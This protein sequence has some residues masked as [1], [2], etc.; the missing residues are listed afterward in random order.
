MAR[1]GL[2]TGGAETQDDNDQDEASAERN[3]FVNQY[4]IGQQF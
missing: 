2:P 4:I 1:L 3:N